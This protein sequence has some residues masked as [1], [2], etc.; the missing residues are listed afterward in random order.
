MK[1]HV[2]RFV[3]TRIVGRDHRFR[4]LENLIKPARIQSVD[5]S[6]MAGMFVN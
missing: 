1:E 5:L 6:Q 2:V 3:S 4:L